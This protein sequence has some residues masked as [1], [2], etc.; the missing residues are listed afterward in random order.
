MTGLQPLTFGWKNEKQSRKDASSSEKH[1]LDMRK[2][3]TKSKK[4]GQR[5]YDVPEAENRSFGGQSMPSPRH[6]LSFTP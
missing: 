5:E 3:F 2:I 6:A 4:L 1:L